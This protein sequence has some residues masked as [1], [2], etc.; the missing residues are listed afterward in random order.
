[1][2]RV[3]LFFAAVALIALGATWLADHPGTVLITWGGR[4]YQ[5]TTLVGLVAVLVVA[6]AVMVLWSVIRFVFNVPSLLSMASRN[7]RRNKGLRALSRGMMAVGAGDAA[8]AKRHASDADRLLQHEPMA[9]LLKAQAAQLAGDRAG[10]QKMFTTM[11]EHDETRALGLRGLHV[12]AQRQGDMEGAYRFASEAQKVATLPWAGQAVLQ[13][14]AAKRD[15]AGALKAVERNAGGRLIDRT[16]ANRQRA[17]LQTAIAL[18][19]EDRSPDEALS[20]AREAVRLA[21]TLVP[22]A[23]LAG[24]LLARRGE[25]RKAA[26]LIET[27]FAATPHPDLA[28]VYINARVGDSAADRLVR[29]ETLARQAPGQPESR[30]TVARAAL[31]AREFG[32][33]RQIMAPLINGEEGNRPSV[34]TCLM[35]ADIEEAEHGETGALFEWLQRAARA[36]HDPVWIADGVMSDT[37]AP[38]SPVTG[39]IDAF[40][41]ESPNEQLSIPERPRLSASR[42]RADQARGPAPELIEDGRDVPALSPEQTDEPAIEPPPGPEEATAAVEPQP[43]ALPAPAPA[44]QPR[45]I[46]RGAKT[47]P[48]V[49]P[50]AAAPDDP[51]PRSRLAAQAGKDELDADVA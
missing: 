42:E 46:G 50:L 17:V 13:Y 51:G 21:P 4:D 35:M 12:E 34:R 15:W 5:F 40:V 33:T 23:A 29:A 2:I 11:L 24:R 44:E 36:P 37:W 30:L 26:K 8:A 28:D 22:A 48:V 18:D 39:R 32:K 49:F 20:L 16:T 7:K 27:A 38:V 41:W 47:Q 6:F 3:L 43:A 10:A 9:M 19:C 14:R 25:L 1:M 31:E 45:R